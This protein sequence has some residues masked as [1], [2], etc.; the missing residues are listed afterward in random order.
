[1]PLVP[2]DTSPINISIIGGIAYIST[3]DGLVELGPAA[4]VIS[5][6]G[7]IAAGTAA[8]LVVCVITVVSLDLNMRIA[9]SESFDPVEKAIIFTGDMGGYVYAKYRENKTI[10]DFDRNPGNWEKMGER[11]EP[12]TGKDYKGG[13]VIEE[14]FRNKQNG[15]V[16][17]RQRIYDS[18]GKV[19]H[20]HLR[21]K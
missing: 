11:S 13:T 5:A 9:E 4:G 15:Q 3:L 2:K 20:D 17:E 19:V 7:A 8:A 21:V 12:A 1:L 16:I 6:I 10:K 18:E 14:S